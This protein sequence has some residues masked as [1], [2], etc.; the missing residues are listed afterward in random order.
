MSGPAEVPPLWRIGDVI[1]GRYEVTRVHEHGGMG[2]VYRVRHLLWGTDLAVKCPRPELFQSAADRERFVTEAEVWVSLG[3]HPNVCACHYVRTLGGIPRVFAE[4]VAGGSLRDWIDDR[5]LYE[6]TER[7]VLTRIT[8][9]AIQTAWGLEHAHSRGLVHQDMKPANVLLDEEGTAKVTDFGLARARAVAMTMPARESAPGVSVLVPAGGLTRAYASPE[10][11]SGESLGRRTDI[12]SF[13]VS[14]LEMF[15]GGITWMAGPI[16]GEALAAYR[17]D[18]PGEAGLPAMPG[19]LADVL[20]R[21]LHLDPADRPGSMAEVATGLAEVHQRISGG[22]YPRAT[23]VA[24]DLRADELNNRGVSL[25]DLDR[26]SE[27][28]E[29]F[30][31][32]LAA[33][34]QHLEATYNTGLHRW[35]HGEVTD[36]ELITGLESI[37]TDAGDPWQAR[38]LLAQVHLERGDLTAAR[39][40]LGELGDEAAGEPEVQ[41]A[42]RTVQS[43][44]LTD[45]RCAEARAIPWALFRNDELTEPDGPYKNGPYLLTSLTPDGR[46]LLTGGRDGMVKLWDLRSGECLQAVEAHFENGHREEVCSIALTP[47]GRFA[48]STGKDHTLRLWDLGTG[49]C[50]RG[51]P[52]RPPPRFGYATHPVA[53]NADASIVLVSNADGPIQIWDARSGQLRRTLAGHAGGVRSIE[54][55]ADCGFLLSTGKTN[56][57]VRFWDLSSGRYRPIRP[58]DTSTVNASCLDPAGRLAVI[59]AQDGTI[60]LWDLRTGRCLQTM[61]APAWVE[62]VSLS[63]D[64]RF[65]LS[66]SQDKTV[67]IW[68]VAGGRCLRTFRGHRAAVRAV[69]LSADGRSAISAGQ[70]NAVRRWDLPLDWAAAPQLSKPRRH[71]ELSRLGSEAEA[72]VFAAMREIAASRYPRALDVLTRAR[73]IPGYQRSPQVL[74]A[75]RALGRHTVRTGLRAAWPTTTFSGHRIYVD[76]VVISTDGTIA[77]SSGGDGTI[78]IWDV[79][80]GAC[81]RVLE[82]HSTMVNDISL[83]ADTQHVLS[84]GHDGKLQ[85]WHIGTGECL[86]VMFASTHDATSARFY[87]GGRRALAAVDGRLQFWDLA[88]GRLLRTIEDCG[89]AHSIWVSPDERVAATVGR[90]KRIM[91]WDLGRRRRLRTLEGHD[92]QVSSVSM[93]ADGRFVVVCGPGCIR[94]WDVASGECVRVLEHPGHPLKARLSTDGRFA[95]S[96]DSDSFLR[97]WD[98]HSGQMLRALE[99]HQGRIRDLAFAPDGSFA[100][101][102][103][104]DG[105]VQRWDFDWELSTREPA[106]WADGATP[107]L[108]LFLARQRTGRKTGGADEL[109]ERLQDAGFGWLRPE[110]VR[111]QLE[112]RTTGRLGTVLSRMWKR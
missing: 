52:L 18:G 68:D 49:R 62:T 88:D 72:L 104:N 31:A 24:A 3:L 74:T 19:E 10:Q 53:L 28:R 11:A 108:E 91:L 25:L 23:P 66:G 71:A 97:V 90:S 26:T 92:D 44:R 79:A 93:S 9:F 59:G 42:L 8:D 84:A 56:G 77:V 75:W 111:A 76:S 15:T 20:E 80:G 12:Y 78:R 51:F 37:R 6:G 33:D 102:A 58:E 47:D 57:E 89:L 81:E 27:A 16:A 35:R 87:D 2:L 69:R 46:L 100:L 106:D 83:S 82:G 61:N 22:P 43:G 41:A 60:S 96:A 85:L 105:T 65:V 64:A 45:A 36:E 109:M 54:L 48:A 7:E 38:H 103:G 1:D 63:A 30:A 112:R 73:A 17:A 40:L 29:A 95:L 107:H 39:T 4:Y 13:A 50:L 21:C 14:V 99:G 55:T 67:R 98:A 34:P 94:L 101:S 110:G 5:R 86:R 32:A 70:D